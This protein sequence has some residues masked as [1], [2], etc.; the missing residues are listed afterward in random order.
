MSFLILQAHG[1]HA[2]PKS[3]PPPGCPGFP[4]LPALQPYRRVSLFPSSFVPPRLDP[5]FRSNPDDLLP[6]IRFGT[7]APRATPKP[8]FRRE[9]YS[10]HLSFHRLG[11]LN[12]ISQKLTLAATKKKSDK[13]EDR[14]FPRGSYGKYNSRTRPPFHPAIVSPLTVNFKPRKVECF[15]GGCR[16]GWGNGT[17]SRKRA[18]QRIRPP[19]RRLQP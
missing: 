13:L 8:E 12:L 14:R 7:V 3:R 16:G 19:S 10:A 17:E 11:Q 4:C 6:L 2:R 1:A 5:R 18:K 15:G 9:S